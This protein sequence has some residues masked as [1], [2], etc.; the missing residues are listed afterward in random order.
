MCGP[1]NRDDF[2]FEWA[3]YQIAEGS[4]QYEISSL[5][6]D[7][8]IICA[9]QLV[10]HLLQRNVAK[11]GRMSRGSNTDENARQKNWHT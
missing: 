11:W 1:L 3:K 4:A 5:F 7:F 2:I 9:L 6:F 8:L 10:A